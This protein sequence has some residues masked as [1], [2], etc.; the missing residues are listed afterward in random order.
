[1][2]CI[3]LGYVFV[4]F[5]INIFRSNIIQNAF[6]HI[7]HIRCGK[8]K[9]VYNSNYVKNNSKPTIVQMCFFYSKFFTKQ[10]QK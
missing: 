8:L 3:V 10:K 2:L 6:S 7:L 5:E 4:F 1:M 9:T